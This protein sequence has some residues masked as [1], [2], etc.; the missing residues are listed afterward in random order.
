M[1]DL[2]IDLHLHTTCSD[3]VFSPERLFEEVR[4]AGLAFFS[5]TDHDTM[6]AYPVPDDLYERL[7]P[8]I[9]IDS[10]LHG[11]TVHLLGYGIAPD[12]PL[13]QTLERQRA[14]RRTR[15]EA[16]IAKLQKLGYEIEYDDVKAQAG[17]AA[18]LGRP[19]LARALLARGIVASV[20]EAFERFLA[21]DGPAF[22]ALKRHS[23]SQII[24][25]THASG[26]IV[27]V[28]HPMRLREPGDLAEL[29]DLHVD[30]IEVGH[31]TAGVDD[32]TRL[33]EFADS[34]GL[35]MTG[36]TDFHAPA[37]EGVA[38]GFKMAQQAIEDLQNALA[39]KRE[40]R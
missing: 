31:P 37:T 5:V 13:L 39:S 40:R 34:R 1:T 10:E 33:R 18:S 30:G 24:D 17:S 16:L 6:S 11:H 20:P 21:D 29:A 14:D 27:V 32:Q 25:L 28:A 19:H 4:S 15:M 8:G 35:L 9:E 38:I 36:G 23:A 22:V 3:G 26:G 12:S 2:L 7:I